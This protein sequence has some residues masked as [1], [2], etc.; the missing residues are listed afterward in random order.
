MKVLVV[1]V[2]ICMWVILLNDMSVQCQLVD[3]GCG[4]FDE[5]SE[6]N[7]TLCTLFFLESNL[8]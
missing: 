5:M 8:L 3:G 7:E 1:L 6:R 2:L 4:V